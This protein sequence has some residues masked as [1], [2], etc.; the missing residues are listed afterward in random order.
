MK[1]LMV[2][3]KFYLKLYIIT[4][5]CGEKKVGFK[6]DYLHTY[7]YPCTENV[8]LSLVLLDIYLKH[9]SG[10]QNFKITPKINTLSL[11][12]FLSKGKLQ[13]FFI[14]SIKISHTEFLMWHKGTGGI[15]GVRRRRFD[16]QPST[17]CGL[18]LNCGLDLIPGWGAPYDTRHPKMEE[19]KVTKPKLICKWLKLGKIQATNLLLYLSKKYLSLRQGNS[20]D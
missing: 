4:F 8:K 7:T 3:F 14:S 15:L 19:K 2:P 18:S 11:K 17:V 10:K 20:N 9:E 16:P 5:A 6:N 1:H 12:V 13:I